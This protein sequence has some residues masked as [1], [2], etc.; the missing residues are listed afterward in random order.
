MTKGVSNMTMKES[1]KVSP[2]T[3]YKS[4]FNYVGRPREPQLACGADEMLDPKVSCHYC[5]DTEHMKDNCVCLN[6]IIACKLQLQEQTITAKQVNKKGTGPHVPTNR[7]SADLKPLWRRFDQWSSPILDHKNWNRI[8]EVIQ[9]I[10]SQNISAQIKFDMMQ[11]AVAT[12]PKVNISCG[13]KRIPSLLD[14]G[15]QV[16]LM[17]HSYSER[18]ILPNIILSSREKAE[19]HQLFQLTAAN[20]GKLP[21]SMYVQL[22]LDF[23]GVMVLDIGVLITLEPYELLDEFHK[24]KLPWVTG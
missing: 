9:S 24:T 22:D 3:Q 18:E 2:C 14:S 5:K 6:N 16:T 12:Y 19:V 20:N 1:P 21:M 7:I 11:R 23:L 4:A 17:C 13:M 8:V 10:T 15:S